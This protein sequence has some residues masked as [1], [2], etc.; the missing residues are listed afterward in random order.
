[1]DATRKANVLAAWEALLK[2][3]GSCGV[4]QHAVASSPSSALQRSPPST[5]KG[6]ILKL[7]TVGFVNGLRLS[8]KWPVCQRCVCVCVWPIGRQ[9]NRGMES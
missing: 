5:C 7:T 4:C 6:I 3:G 8:N 1:M 2:Q 9:C